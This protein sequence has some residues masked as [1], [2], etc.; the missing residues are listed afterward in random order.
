MAQR[1]GLSPG[2]VVGGRYQIVR[3]LGEGG[4]GAVF[5]A[6]HQVLG[7]IVAIKVLKPDVATHE[8]F[9]GRF[10]QEAKS[11]AELH[12]KHIVEISDFGVAIAYSSVLI[13]CMLAAIGL[14]QLGVG[15]QR[16]AR[17]SDGRGQ[18]MPITMEAAS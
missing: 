14:I 10:L 3:L 16:R 13:L 5:E 18:P 7:R 4:M 8:Q 11:A 9:A 17:R 1:L 2:D 6:R 15:E 12:H